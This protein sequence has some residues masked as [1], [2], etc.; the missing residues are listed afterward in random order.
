MLKISKR[1]SCTLSQ[2]LTAAVFVLLTAAL[3]LLPPVLRFIMDVFGKPE[4]YFLPTLILFYVSLPPAFAADIS[5]HLLLRNVRQEQIFTAKSSVYLCAIS[6]C[7]MLETV[8]FFVLGFWY[9]TLFLLSFA[10]LFIGVIL[11]VVKNVIEEASAIKAEND[12]TI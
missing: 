5:L 7:C 6:W 8:I 4:S 11:R 1:A 2:I 3:F 10:A 9:L 12:F